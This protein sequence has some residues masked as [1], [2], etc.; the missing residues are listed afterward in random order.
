MLRQY[1]V[2]ILWVAPVSRG[3]LLT[4]FLLLM[5]VDFVTASPH[6]DVGRVTHS[7]VVIIGLTSGYARQIHRLYLVRL[8]I[9]HRLGVTFTR[10]LPARLLLLKE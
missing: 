10:A 8:S 2:L 9:F 3:F 7:V 5:L 1:L 6:Y 4:T